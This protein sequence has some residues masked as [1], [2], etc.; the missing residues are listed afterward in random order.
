MLCGLISQ[1]NSG[2]RLAGPSN[3][4]TLLIKRVR[5]QGFIVTDYA[6]RFP[7]AAKQ[8]AGW[9]LQGKLKYRL[10]MV[11]GLRAAPVALNRLFDG[12]NVGKLLVKVS[13]E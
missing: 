8:I 7:E 13:D 12:A 4:G 5:L 6:A 10:D 1:Y 9:L 3:F 11:E 2:S